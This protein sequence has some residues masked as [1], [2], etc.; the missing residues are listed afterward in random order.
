MNRMGSACSIP[1]HYESED[2]MMRQ[3]QGRTVRR[4]P[5][6]KKGWVYCA[7]NNGEKGLV[8]PFFYSKHCSL[9]VTNGRVHGS[10]VLVVGGA[11]RWA[12]DAVAAHTMALLFLLYSQATP[13]AAG[14]GITRNTLRHSVVGAVSRELTR[15]AIYYWLIFVGALPLA[16]EPRLVSSRIFLFWFYLLY[17]FSHGQ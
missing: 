9:L 10:H 8:V 16:L 17:H 5:C 3:Q 1:R 4:C 7:F 11:S 2:S 15:G 13:R 6:C 12:H 14:N